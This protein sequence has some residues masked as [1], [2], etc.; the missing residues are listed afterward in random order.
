MK[1]TLNKNKI[2]A[3]PV[4]V[5]NRMCYRKRKYSEEKAKYVVKNMKKRRVVGHEFLHHYC[6]PVCGYFHVGKTS[7]SKEVLTATKNWYFEDF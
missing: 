1:Q 6:C 5:R 3:K 4:S 7:S 2:R